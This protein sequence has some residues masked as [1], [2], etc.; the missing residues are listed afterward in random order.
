VEK[1]GDK[2]KIH[3][4]PN[5]ELTQLYVRFHN[6]AEKQAENGVE[7]GQD[8][9]KQEARDIFKSLEEG[10]EER[11][12]LWKWI[13]AE[14]LSDLEKTFARLG[15]EFD[16]IMG[17]SFYL[18]MADEVIKEGE[19][20]GVFVEGEGGALIFEMGEGQV[21]GLL[22]KGDGATLYLTRDVAT[23]KYRVETWKPEAILYVVDHAQSL[24]FKQNFAVARG[25]GYDGA[26]S[27]GFATALEH[28]S[29]GRMNFA[30]RAM[31]TRKG[32]VI[33]AKELLDEAARRAGKLSQDRGSELSGE[34][35]E[36][37][38]EVAGIASVKYAIL[39]QDRVKD[40]IFDWNKIITLEGNSAPYL[41][42]SYA[43]ANSILK[44]ASEGGGAAFDLSGM[45]EL[46]DEAELAMVRK[47]M[48]FPDV[49]EG[50]AA[51]R[52]PHVICTYLFELC[53]DFN[54]FYGAVPVIKADT[55]IQK[56]TRLG[57]V[58]SFMH[59]LKAGLAILGVPVL[60]KM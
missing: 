58:T 29:F 51:E 45:P 59:Q 42:Y 39:S 28:I 53:H 14:S 27:L 33:K 6:E 37:E 35:L 20:R 7:E 52:K 25:M 10:D 24:H 54:R 12:E 38:A 11:L 31:S 26:A 60:E 13:V 4:N 9:L 48:K 21:P 40:I 3:A 5:N 57:I 17:E 44:K 2:K 15:V 19:E 49:L 23:I 1:W 22:R 47:M 43:R 8:D 50:A 30:D 41:L 36:A 56:R 46:T 34:E 55:E 16:H 18:D 32:N